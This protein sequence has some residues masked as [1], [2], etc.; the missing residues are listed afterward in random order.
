MAGHTF[1]IYRVE[2]DIEKR[3]SVSELLKNET[4]IVRVP[5]CTVRKTLNL[6]IN[7]DDGL[8]SDLLFS[9]SYSEPDCDQKK[10]IEKSVAD[11]VA[12][13]SGNL[14]LMFMCLLLF[15]SLFN[16]PSVQ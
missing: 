2:P 4:C 3:V 16:Q 5:N 13:V 15:M 1:V 7:S 8:V 10:N 11:G 12:I 14:L 9:H 6:K